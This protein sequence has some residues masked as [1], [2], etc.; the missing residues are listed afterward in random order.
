MDPQFASCD[1]VDG[2]PSMM[3]QQQ[4]LLQAGG[5]PRVPA[6]AVHLADQ[7]ERGGEKIEDTLTRF[8]CRYQSL[9]FLASWAVLIAAVF[10]F[11]VALFHLELS[12]LINSAFLLVLGFL[13]MVLDVPGTPR[14]AGRYRR[15]VRKHARF[16]TR[17]TGKAVALLY[18]GTLVSGCL[19]PR[20]PA[21]SGFLIILTIFLS[22]F[23]YFVG[24]L[25]L[26][27][28]LRKSLRLERLRRSL[29][30][31]GWPD[32][33]RKYAVNDPTHG[34]QFQEFNRMASDYSQGE[35]LFDLSDLNLIFNALDEHQKTAINEVEFEHW[36]SSDYPGDADGPQRSSCFSMVYL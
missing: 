14:W 16:L 32:M 15:A 34:M 13:I 12:V 21:R 26:C 2:Y 27:L 3:D 35:L 22:L 28:A 20:R 31:A 17:L 10:S 29:Q 4:E 7:L 25:G 36:V 6:S 18:L 33:Y 30:S 5:F 23:I 11:P 19:W 8:N 9:F 1:P 24:L